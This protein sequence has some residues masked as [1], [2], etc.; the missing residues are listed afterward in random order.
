LLVALHEGLAA[1]L[2]HDAHAAADDRSLEKK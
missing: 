2:G 1:G